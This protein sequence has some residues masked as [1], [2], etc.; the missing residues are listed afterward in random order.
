MANKV[1]IIGKMLADA[2]KYFLLMHG[3]FNKAKELSDL[4]NLKKAFKERHDKNL[5][6][7]KATGIGKIFEA[8]IKEEI[9]ILRPAEIIRKNETKVEK[10]V[11]EKLAYIE[12]STGLTPPKTLSGEFDFSKDQASVTLNF[13]DSFYKHAWSDDGVY[14]PNQI[15]ATY[16]EGKFTLG[17]GRCG[18]I[19]D[20][21]NL[22]GVSK[23][24]LVTKVG[25]QIVK[26][27]GLELPMT[28][29]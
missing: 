20:I 15:V 21:E 4:D 25:E 10:N 26:A 22:T 11:P 27:K 2:N 24:D 16:H 17:H 23:E 28:R 7:L 1:E 29:K 12:W 5:A 9:V 3:T 14:I 8:I 19:S 18:L 6:E 13:D